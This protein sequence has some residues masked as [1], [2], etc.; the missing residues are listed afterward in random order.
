MSEQSDGKLKARWKK[1]GL[2]EIKV[3]MFPAA[4]TQL[5]REKQPRS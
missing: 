3:W 2:G 4:R 5:R 1:K